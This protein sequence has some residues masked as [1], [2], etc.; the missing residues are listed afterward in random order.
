VKSGGARIDAREQ[1]SMQL[2]CEYATRPDQ[3]AQRETVLST[4]DFVARPSSQI[5]G[6]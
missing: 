6:H 2:N 5:A 4:A 1:R 3:L